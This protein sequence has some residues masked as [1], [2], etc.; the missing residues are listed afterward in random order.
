M[1]VDQIGAELLAHLIVCGT[2]SRIFVAQEQSIG[3]VGC[4]EGRRIVSQSKLK[5]QERRSNLALWHL[6]DPTLDDYLFDRL[7]LD[8]REAL[9]HHT[10]CCSQ[11]AQ[12]L[13]RRETLVAL[14]K[15]CLS[16]RQAGENA[17]STANSVVHVQVARSRF[18]VCFKNKLGNR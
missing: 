12:E 9:E 17:S 5:W 15:A 18:S 8:E 16:E 10:G 2:C 13:R 11:C 6:A 1:L 3:D 4:V 7:T 14:I